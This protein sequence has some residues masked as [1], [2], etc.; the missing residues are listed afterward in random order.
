MAEVVS[1]SLNYTNT[2]KIKI[3]NKVILFYFIAIL[4]NI[5]ILLR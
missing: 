1:L 4:I 2:Y 5:L 3:S